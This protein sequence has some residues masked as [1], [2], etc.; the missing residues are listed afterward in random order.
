MG[1][2][3]LE[4]PTKEEDRASWVTLVLPFT[5]CPGTVS[6]VHLRDRSPLPGHSCFV[7]VK[8]VWAFYLGCGTFTFYLRWGPGPL[9]LL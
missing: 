8:F 1:A 4:S 7:E 2:C 3:K 5:S 6:S 9:M